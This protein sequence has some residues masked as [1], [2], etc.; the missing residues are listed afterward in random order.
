[1]SHLQWQ[2]NR[3]AI[4]DGAWMSNCITHFNVNVITYLCPKFMVISVGIYKIPDDPVCMCVH[5]VQQ[6][7]LTLTVMY[8]IPPRHV[9]NATTYRTRRQHRHFVR[10]NTAN[11]SQALEASKAQWD[12]FLNLLFIHL[13]FSYSINL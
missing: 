12:F 1:M 5:S 8:V 2:F 3:T 7:S 6:C 10:Q 4:E 13:F 9:H 11:P